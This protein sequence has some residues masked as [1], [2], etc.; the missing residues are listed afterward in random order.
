MH[1]AVIHIDQI[2]ERIRRYIADHLLPEGSEPLQDDEDL[3]G[4]L[5]SLQI[6]RMLIEL[7]SL[8]QFKVANSELSAENLGTIDRLSSF[9]AQKLS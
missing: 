8:Y 4:R 1:D 5:D 6:L 2:R 7:E 9:V 3:L